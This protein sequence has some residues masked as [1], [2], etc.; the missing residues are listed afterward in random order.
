MTNERQL[1]KDC[2]KGKPAAQKAL[3]EQFAAQMLGVCY[4]YTKSMAD[5]EDVLQEGMVKVFTYLH[6]Y[7]GDG[8]LGAWVRRIMV[9]TAINYL[10]KNSRYQYDLSFSADNQA[11]LHPVSQENPELKL[12]A[13]ELADMIRQL[14]PGY[15]TIFNLHAVEGYTHVEISAMLGIHEGTS[16]S[17][18]LR[19]RNLLVSW[20]K[21]E[22]ESIESNKLA[23]YA[24]S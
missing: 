16:R 12:N 11:Y 4:R 5:A 8:D 7:R 15:Q 24:R 19:A 20:I 21:K 14:P 18:Y 10:K 2:L 6:Q 17:Q 1:V 22:N 13:K 23:H 3:Y 9:T